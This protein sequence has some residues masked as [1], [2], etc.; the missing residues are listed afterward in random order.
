MR[1][2]FILYKCKK[3]P[4]FFFFSLQTFKGSHLYDD[5]SEACIH[6]SLLIGKFQVLKEA[7]P[8]RVRHTDEKY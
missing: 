2:F 7:I 6:Y 5:N 4:F 8:I 3:N 1:I